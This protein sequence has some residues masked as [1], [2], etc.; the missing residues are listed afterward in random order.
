MENIPLAFAPLFTRPVWHHAELLM[1]EAILAHG[2]Q[3]VP[4]QVPQ[5]CAPAIADDAKQSNSR[6]QFAT[7]GTP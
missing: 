3:T 4:Q 2:K 6:S 1:L 5:M 7:M